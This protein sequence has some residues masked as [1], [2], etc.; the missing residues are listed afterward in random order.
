[1][2]QTCAPCH[3]RNE[4][5]TPDFQPGDNYHDHYRVT[6][7]TDPAV[8]YPDG[9]QRDEDFNWTSVLLS[10]MG[11]AGVT[12]LDCHDPHSNKTIIPASDNMLCLQCHTAPG[13]PQPNGTKA[14]PIDPLTHTRH[15]PSA[16]PAANA[17]PATCRPPPTCSGPRAT[18]T[19][20][21]A[22]IR[23]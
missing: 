23:S 20:G 11:H 18:T 13:R 4:L 22:P 21:S 9:Q 5:L 1:M 6:L 3:A 8:Y 16:A 12:C 2:M 14:I 10:R 15:Q 17:S 19:A 7:P